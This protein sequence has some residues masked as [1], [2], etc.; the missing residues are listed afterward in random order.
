MSGNRNES[1]PE[2]QIRIRF[3]SRDGSING[4]RTL[5]RLPIRL[6]RN[7]LNECPISHP[8]VSDFHALIERVG[9]ELCV[10]DLDSRN[11][12]SDHALTPI[13]AGRALPL[14]SLR[15]RFVLGRVVDVEIE[16]VEGRGSSRDD[17][18]R[19]PQT[20]RADDR[21]TF[22]QGG[23]PRRAVA[24]P[25]L[26]QLSMA[27]AIRTA[28]ESGSQRAPSM[29]ASADPSLPPIAP[30][31][32]RDDAE[33]SDQ[34]RPLE[35]DRDASSAPATEHLPMNME[36][37][38]LLGLRELA[39]SLVP[40]SKLETTGDVARLL[41]GIHD[42]L[43]VF[44][45]CLPSLRDG[46]PRPPRNRS[47]VGS[48]I[49]TGDADA[50]A[51]AL[52]DWRESEYGAASLV[53]RILTEVVSQRDAAEDQAQGRLAQALGDL[54]PDVLERA[55]LEKYSNPFVR[56]VRHRLLWEAF[57]ERYAQAVAPSL[58]RDDSR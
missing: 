14:R 1:M 24:A 40:G 32:S 43:E 20:A 31:R 13:L 6:G 11:G 19:M 35:Q 3:R 27:P 44:C 55:V 36:A 41:T 34:V 7:T 49:E 23:A 46:L 47:L 56:L 5:R 38:A 17:R 2:P 57:A 33:E 58:P 9:G 39:A 51:A 18:P 48:R 53:E 28:T 22:G 37:L 12:V 4:E 54:S 29:V 10:R 52:L 25:P 15:F 8:F 50:V 45:R 42:A 26:P 30:T 21:T 16:A